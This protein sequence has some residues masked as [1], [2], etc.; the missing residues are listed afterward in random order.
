MTVEA[1]S[2]DR[3]VKHWD[4]KSIDELMTNSDI[5][6]TNV[7][8]LNY[9]NIFGYAMIEACARRLS[10]KGKKF[11]V[12]PAVWRRG[13]SLPI[14]CHVNAVIESLEQAGYVHDGLVTHTSPE[15]YSQNLLKLNR[16]ADVTK[17]LAHELGWP[18]PPGEK[19]VY[20][21]A[22][23]GMNGVDGIWPLRPRPD[24]DKPNMK[25]N[26]ISLMK[27]PDAAMGLS[28]VCSRMIE[29]AMD[30]LLNQGKAI[31]T[32]LHLKRETLNSLFKLCGAQDAEYGPSGF[33]KCEFVERW[34]ELLTDGPSTDEE[35][36]ELMKQII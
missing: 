13:E 33:Y 20:E 35:L 19:G 23:R 21:F 17:K 6:I 32:N 12:A 29:D 9:D 8:R 30:T 5:Y 15:I 3:P 14:Y 28:Y 25:D 18:W 2:R 31:I 26:I 27:A 22:I 11:R 10:Y 24:K 7:F 34:G 1:V 16:T 36:E 4:G